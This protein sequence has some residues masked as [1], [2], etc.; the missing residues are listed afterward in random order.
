MG[1]AR[2]VGAG[3][4]AHIKDAMYF[5]EVVVFEDS[6]KFLL[7]ERQ[8]REVEEKRLFEEIFKQFHGR[9]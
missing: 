7:A 5:G 2:S 3:P 8:L 1:K 6:S 9:R 4:T